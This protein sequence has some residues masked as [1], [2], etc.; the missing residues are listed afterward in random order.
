MDAFANESTLTFLR[1]YR[2]RDIRIFDNKYRT[3]KSES[4]KILYDPDKGS[5]AMRKGLWML[6]ED[7]SPIL[8][9]VYFG[10]MDGKQRQEDFVDINATWSGLDCV[11][12][13]ST[14]EAGISFEIPN[15]FDAIIAISN[16]NTGVHVEAFAQM[17]Y[18]VRDC[19]SRIV[20]LYHSKK[21]SEI[22]KE[23]NRD[24]IRAELSALRPRDL[25]TV[26]KG[27][28][29]WDKIAD[30]YTLDSSPT[31]ETYIEVEYQRRLSAKYFPEILCSLIASTGASL[32]LVS[33]ENS[34]LAKADRVNVSNDIK[35]TAKKIEVAEA[36][37]IANSTD[38]DPSEAEL[39]KQIPTRSFTDNMILQR[40]YLWKIYASGDIGGKNDIRDWSMDNTDWT[41]LCDI[42]F[43][44]KFNSPEPLQHFRRLA[45]F[46]RQGS[47]TIKAIENLKFKETI[48]WEESQDSLDPASNDLHK[49]YS[50]K[51]WEAVHDLFQSLGFSDIDDTKILS[52]DDVSKAFEQSWEKIVKIRQDAL[53][54]FGF[55][56]L[57]DL[58]AT[59]KLINAIAGNWCGYT[60]KTGTPIL[61]PYKPEEPEVQCSSSSANY[62]QELFDSI[63]VADTNSKFTN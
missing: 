27:R 56:E 7:G 46:R 39:L 63:S 51:Q 41:K 29:E 4:V 52:G 37:L 54:L 9:R 43:V 35:G 13:T 15:H 8:T 61:P 28:R 50:A 53:L 20:S 6:Q 26:I 30:C 10:Q 33:V 17:L 42:D 57:P 1:Q 45:Y 2:G 19:P 24:L 5:E 40:H 34:N 25:P 31:V 58:K 49:S 18:R 47:N 21:P 11:I 14:V 59:V 36:E 16:I 60:I 44:K 48:Q 62:I 12:Y 38:I 32:D 23:P 55:K 3:R 22:F